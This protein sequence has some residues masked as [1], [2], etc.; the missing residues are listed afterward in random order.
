MQTAWI[1][2][3][4]QITLRLTH[5]QAVWHSDNTFTKFEQHWSTMI[6]KQKRNL[7]ARGPSGVV[8]IDCSKAAVTLSPYIVFVFHNYIYIQLNKP[9]RTFLK[10]WEDSIVRLNWQNILLHTLKKYLETHSKNFLDA[11]FLYLACRK[12]K[13]TSHINPVLKL[14]YNTNGKIADLW[15]MHGGIQRGGQNR[16]LRT[17][18]WPI[19][20]W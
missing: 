3:R 19:N 10:R 17:R 15:L 7:A 6:L 18:N 16:L 14:L 11:L 13:I 4:H 8:T 1:L 9:L 20:W 12:C 2:M 5:F